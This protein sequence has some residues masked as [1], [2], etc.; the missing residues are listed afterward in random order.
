M[1]RKLT[2]APADFKARLDPSSE[3]WKDARFDELDASH[4]ML[5]HPN[6]AI[7][8]YAHG[9]PPLEENILLPTRVTE[10]IAYH[11]MK[12]HGFYS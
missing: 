1:E 3:Y 11:I 7:L 5:C 10:K 9:C 12:N 2:D 6:G 4:M 8:I